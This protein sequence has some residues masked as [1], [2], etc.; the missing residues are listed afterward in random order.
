VSDLRNGNASPELLIGLTLISAAIFFTMAVSIFS[1]GIGGVGF[2]FMSAFSVGFTASVA[3]RVMSRKLKTAVVIG[4]VVGAVVGIAYLR[5]Q[6]VDLGNHG[7]EWSLF[8]LPV[9]V[10]AGRVFS[11]SR[12]AAWFVDIF[13]KG[14]QGTD[15]HPKISTPINPDIWAA[16]SANGGLVIF[17]PSLQPKNN[18]DHVYYYDLTDRRLKR[19]H[20]DEIAK[21]FT[22]TNESEIRLGSIKEYMIWKASFGD[23]AIREVINEAEKQEKI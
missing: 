9:A 2:A 17:D 1:P 10:I 12:P 5:W 8:T 20:K 3:N 18:L 13:R 15:D 7:N 21:E 22:T 19:I 23:G 14:D 4:L 11:T 16:H 6:T